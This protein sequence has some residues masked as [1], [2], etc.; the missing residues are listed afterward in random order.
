MPNSPGDRLAGED[1]PP[2]LGISRLALH[3]VLTSMAVSKGTTV[4]LGLTVETLD[5]H[6]DHVDVTFTDGSQGR[7]DLVVGADGI[8]SKIRTMILPKAPK[9]HFTGQ[10]VWRYN[11]ARRPEID[12]LAAY[13]G[14]HA[15]AG[16]VPLSQDI[17]YMYVT[18]IEPGNPWMDSSQLHTLMCDRMKDFGG[19]LAELKPEIND[20]AKVVYKPMEIVM[21][22]PP[23]HVG[24][25]VLLGDAAHATTPHLGQGA[26][27]AIEDAVVLSQELTCGDNVEQQLERYT[28]RRYERCRFIVE[29]S[30]RIGKWQM[31]EIEGVDEKD[32]VEQM[33][34]VTAAPI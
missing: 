11:F 25:V 4:R 20:P 5:Q 3:E 9:P 13:N 21:V 30:E 7:Y 16:L 6:E 12:H 22:P 31:N 28:E 18:S 32:M 33:Q 34:R 24:R 10:A 26:G 23:W 2:L 17:M 27:M 29:N 14:R 19:L 1:Y 8:F 15:S